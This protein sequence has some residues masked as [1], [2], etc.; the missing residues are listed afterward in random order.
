MHAV[1]SRCR[2]RAAAALRAACAIGAAWSLAFEACAA[3]TP[4][5]AP[6]SAPASATPRTVAIENMRFAPA[7]LHVRR[8]ERIVW[9]ND[10]LVPH[11]VSAKDGGFDSGAIAPGASWSL[12]TS[13][14][15]TRV[16]Y[17]KFHGG[18]DATVVVD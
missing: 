3:G 2:A 5:A 8:G 7:I 13:A 6:P 1:H 17:C 11:T 18:M 12:A 4:R 10:D 14:H 16:Y 9:V 15:G